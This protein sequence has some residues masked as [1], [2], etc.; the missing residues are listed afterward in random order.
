M[1]TFDRV[2]DAMSEQLHDDLHDH[3]ARL[4]IDSA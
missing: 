1:A 4:V 2:S 3:V